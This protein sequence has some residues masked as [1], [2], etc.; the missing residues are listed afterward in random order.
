MIAYILYI[1]QHIPDGRIMSK[2]FDNNG[3]V[4]VVIEVELEAVPSTRTQTGMIISSRS[5]E[6]LGVLF[7]LELIQF[8]DLDRVNMQVST[9]Q[10]QTAFNTDR[11]IYHFGTKSFPV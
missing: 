8:T 7:Q 9:K 11:S 5:E 6:C 3:H 1:H 10:P 2:S 4:L